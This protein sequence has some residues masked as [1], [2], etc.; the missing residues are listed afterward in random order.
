MTYLDI[1][2]RTSQFHCIVSLLSVSSVSLYAHMWQCCVSAVSACSKTH[3]VEVCIQC[4]LLTLLYLCG[5]QLSL[6]P[7]GLQNVHLPSPESQQE[8]YKMARQLPVGVV[9]VRPWCYGEL[10][11]DALM[12]QLDNAVSLCLCVLCDVSLIHY[13]YSAMYNVICTVYHS[14]IW[15]GNCAA[16]HCV[17][18]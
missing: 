17:C 5:V 8:A 10:E 15:H 13:M 2:L 3:V 14:K 16:F 12:R 18:C 6:V 7:F 4:M 11:F 9:S 1:V